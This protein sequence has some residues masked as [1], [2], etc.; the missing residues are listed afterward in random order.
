MA[1]PF[2]VTPVLGVDL[3]TLSLAVNIANGSE[4][5]PQLGA[6]VFGTDGRRY[7]YGQAGATISANLTTCLPSV[8]TF[9]VAATGGSYR[10]PPVAMAVGDRGYFSVASV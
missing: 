4:D 7:M 9:I 6:Q 2:T 3:N 1:S 10:S 8:T 5:A